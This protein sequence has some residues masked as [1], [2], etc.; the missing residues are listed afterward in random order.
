MFISTDVVREH[1]E[2]YFTKSRHLINDDR[3]LFLLCIQCFEV[4]YITNL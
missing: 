1:L 2:N 3:S 4:N